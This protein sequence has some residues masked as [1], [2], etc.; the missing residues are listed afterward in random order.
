MLPESPD[1]SERPSC[2][3]R[4]RAEGS[5]IGRSAVRMDTRLGRLEQPT[6]YRLSLFVPNSGRAPEGGAR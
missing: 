6:A 4:L 5:R 2:K 1:A 3:R